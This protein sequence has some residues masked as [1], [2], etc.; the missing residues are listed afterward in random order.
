MYIV[1]L[2]DLPTVDE[3]VYCFA[4]SRISKIENYGNNSI[5]FKFFNRFFMKLNN[6]VSKIEVFYGTLF[7]KLID[8][9]NRQEADGEGSIIP[10]LSML[11]GQIVISFNSVPCNEK[12]IMALF[13]HA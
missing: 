3:R 5:I 13:Q 4:E 11:I 10:H 7:S 1:L 6:V 9:C 2:Q 12:A 8:A